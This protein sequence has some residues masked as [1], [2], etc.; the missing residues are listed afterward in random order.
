MTDNDQNGQR[1]G[2]KKAHAAEP[3]APGAATVQKNLDR[4]DLLTISSAAITKLHDRISGQRFR[5]KQDDPVLLAF[6][7]ATAQ[8]MT[9]HNALLRD[10]AMD[11]ILRRLDALEAKQK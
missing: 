3:P 6:V 10:E 9:A 1:P 7:R 2:T 11:E 8:M 5:A 4:G